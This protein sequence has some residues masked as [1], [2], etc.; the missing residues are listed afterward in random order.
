MQEY[1][2]KKWILQIVALQIG[3]KEFMSLK[4]LKI[5]CCI[6]DISNRRP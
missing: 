4:K 3:L 1:Q 6:A 5:K 2:N